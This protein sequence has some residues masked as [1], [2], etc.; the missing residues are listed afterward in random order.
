MHT[1]V[2]F[3]VVGVIV[4]GCLAGVLLAV[5]WPVASATLPYAAPADPPLAAVA[6]DRPGISGLVDTKWVTATSASTGIP[7]RALAAYAGAAI[8][9]ATSLPGCG[10]SW[11]SL[12]AIGY[13]ESRHG[14]AGG[15]KLDDNGTAIPG[16]F[17]VAL[18][19]GSTENI[20][21]SDTGTIDGDAAFD[22][23][24]G[25]MQLIPQ[26]WR[27][28]HTDASGDG[29]EDPQN[30][31]DAVMATANYLCRASKDMAHPAGWRTGISAFNSAP[32]YLR[33]V[34]RLAN[35]YAG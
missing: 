6:T 35:E 22:R 17:G 4:L 31:D 14:T 9:K 7:E 25:P 34:A 33:S 15:S 10:L 12:A 2:T 11:N 18:S 20:P 30:I 1:R 19:G 29:I 3:A 28:W 5:R 26:T 16:I 32:S 24:I 13:V 23:A 27:N 8:A 21:D